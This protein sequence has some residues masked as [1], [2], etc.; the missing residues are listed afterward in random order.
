LVAGFDGGVA[1]VFQGFDGVRGLAHE[2][3]GA[4]AVVGVAAK[5]DC[6][7][8]L[9]PQGRLGRVQVNDVLFQRRGPFEVTEMVIPPRA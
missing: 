6:R 8:K 2:F 7:T 5:L 4:G 1:L 3:V 9:V